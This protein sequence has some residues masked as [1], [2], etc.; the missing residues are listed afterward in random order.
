M[1]YNISYYFLLFIGY[2]YLGWICETIVCSIIQK[3]VVLERGF[4]LGPICPIYGYGALA[5]IQILKDFHDNPLTLFLTALIGASILE[6]ITSYILEKIFKTRWWDYT[7]NKF[8]IN[9]RICLSF[10]LAFG[11]LSLIITYLINPIFINILNNIKPFIIQ[12]TA[13]LIFIIY[14]IDNIVTFNTLS[15]LRHKLK[16]S[17]KDATEEINKKIKNKIKK[18]IKQKRKK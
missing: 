12:I 6:Y 17:N 2:S 9:G 5:V 3:K 8:N 13:M 7:K 14:L 4:L 1:L 11:I 18:K 10:S 16:K 15:E